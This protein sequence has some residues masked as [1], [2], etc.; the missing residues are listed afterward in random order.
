MQAGTA[1]QSTGSKTIADL[2]GLAADR[3]GDRVAVIHKVDGSWR[4][5]TFAEVGEIVSEVIVRCAL[6]LAVIIDNEVT[7]KTHQPVL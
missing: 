3:F 6:A 7:R 1:T 2:I 5:V 4:D